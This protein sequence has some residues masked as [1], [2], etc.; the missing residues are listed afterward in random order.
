VKFILLEKPRLSNVLL[1]PLLAGSLVLAGCSS[2]DDD[3]GSAGDNGTLVDVASNGGT[4]ANNTDGTDISNA[5]SVILTTVASDFS[6]SALE[7]FSLS[8]PREGST[9]LSPGVSD[10]IVR[11]FEDQYFVIRRFMSDSI[12]AYNSSD[13]STIIF[14]STTND[15][16]DP[17]SSN[18]QDLVFVNSEKA[19]LLR[20]GSPT[21][22]VVNPSATSVD[23]FR[24]GEIDLSAY[25]PDGIPEAA[26]GIVVG[27]QL[28]IFMQRLENFV[29]VREGA[30]A[31]IDIN[32]DT[33][34]DT[35][36]NDEFMGIILP[37]FN[38]SDISFDAA[39]NTIF[40]QAF[41]DFGAG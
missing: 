13:P 16:D 30:V 29:P 7:I 4:D 19:Y 2:D 9:G 22:L 6:S 15:D 28:F 14:E 34:I 36:T 21:V 25:D 37:A 8:E 35:G 38:P 12:A 33:E 18:P 27:D 1:I 41:G 26:S 39:S 32:T 17:A 5:N 40:A 11:S 20:L 23:D 10:T 24:L 31:V 3:D